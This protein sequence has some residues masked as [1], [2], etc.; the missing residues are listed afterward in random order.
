MVKIKTKTAFQ[1]TIKGVPGP[2]SSVRTIS[3]GA[4]CYPSGTINTFSKLR[5]NKNAK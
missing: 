4:L 1:N 2:K 5:S 3:W